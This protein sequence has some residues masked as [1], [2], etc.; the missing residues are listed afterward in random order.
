MK[1]IGITGGIGSG[2][3]TVCEIFKLLGVAVFHADEE[4]KKLQ[5]SDRSIRNQLVELFGSTIYSEAGI[6]DRGALANII[7]KDKEA[8]RKVNA[9]IHP[10]VKKQFMEWSCLH[11]NDEYVLYEAAI[12]IES[13]SAAD[14]YRN[15]LIIADEP[16][17]IQR[18]M[19]RDH[20]SEQ[21][22]KERIKN[23]MSDAQKEKIVDYV[24][25]NDNKTLLIPQIIKL[26]QK[27]RQLA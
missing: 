6:L 1:Y 11:S 3:S 8:L 18:V 19:L 9:I 20:I 15:I 24:L 17:R 12:L 26:D 16:N 23:Q 10:V 13:G 2:K 22:V 14:F 21:Q 7:F 5:N 27:I 4:A 25:Y